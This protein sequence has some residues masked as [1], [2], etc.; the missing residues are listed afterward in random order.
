MLRKNCPGISPYFVGGGVLKNQVVI[1]QV[2][3]PI[4]IGMIEQK[5]TTSIRGEV[6]G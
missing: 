6:F 1:N 3:N 5:E 4:L 2:K